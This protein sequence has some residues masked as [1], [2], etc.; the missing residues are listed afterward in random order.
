[1]AKMEREMGYIQEQFN[2]AEQTYGQDVLNLVLA[3]GYLAKLMANEAVLRHLTKKHPDM[4]SEFDSIV[5]LV[6]LEK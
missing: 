1:M 5:R 6:M 2:L 3:K 4:L